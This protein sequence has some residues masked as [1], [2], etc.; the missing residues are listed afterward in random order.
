MVINLAV[1]LLII[2]VWV[3]AM[4]GSLSDVANGV[5]IVLEFGVL[6]LYCIEVE[7]D[8]VVGALAVGIRVEVVA[9]VNVN[10][11]PA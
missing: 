5:V 8:V 1:E 2:D 11:S 6:V 3:D 4:I 7:S 10:M 9:D